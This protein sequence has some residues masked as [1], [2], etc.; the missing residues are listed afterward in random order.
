MQ[1]LLGPNGQPLGQNYRVRKDQSPT[2]QPRVGDG[3]GIWAGRTSPYVEL[4]GG[5]A[6]QFD[7]S[8]LTMADYRQMRE[9]Y[10]ISAS[11]NVLMFGLY[12]TDWRITGSYAPAV[13]LIEEEIHRHWPTLVRTFSTA[14]WAGYTPNAINYHNSLDGKTRI[15]NI[16]D[17]VP[18]E[19]TVNW[20]VEEGWAPAGRVK[21][22]IH[23][24]DG[25]KHGGFWIPPENTLWYPLLMEGGDYYG[26]KLLKSAFVPWYF[27][28]L[29][30]LYTNR[31]F[32]RFGEP[33]PI[34]RGDFNAQIETGTG[35]ISGRKAMEQ[36]VQG[37][38]NGAT[39]VLPS[40]RDPETREYDFDLD[41]VE[42]QMRGADWE[43]YLSRLDEEMSMAVFTPILLFRTADVGS[44][45]LGQ[46]HMLVFQQMLTALAADWKQ[47]MDRFIIERLHA[48]NFPGN[49]EY[50]QWDFRK[51]GMSDLDRYKEIFVEMIR[52]DRATPSLED[53]AAVSGLEWTEVEQLVEEPAA[54]APGEDPDDDDGAEFRA[55][56]IRP[57]LD[58]AARRTASQFVKGGLCVLSH[59]N[60]VIE[61][62]VADGME[63]SAAER[64]QA[65]LY[66]EVNM[67]IDAARGA[68]LDAT[69]AYEL[70][71]GAVDEAL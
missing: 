43:R 23:H 71:M 32:E 35:T 42:S 24:Y 36:V 19:C 1:E 55:E 17:L 6:L 28:Q 9:H 69:Q 5:A 58:E 61:A 67:M 22:K 53:I 47:F 59:R 44:Y 68:D 46:Q 2:K 27:S 49:Y 3:F 33:T 63:E 62:M 57:I 48:L 30:H 56:T 29:I 38:R 20:R 52:K 10:Q 13:E 31:Y 39:V 70:I 60:R 14:H 15:K 34:G 51:Q 54:V 45:D 21:P 50:P 12:Q 37:F 26:R 41:Y 8:K 18:E 64:A 66:S 4:P 65:A 11:L 25:I 40:D 16:K 7:L